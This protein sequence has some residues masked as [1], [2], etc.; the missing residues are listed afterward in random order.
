MCIISTVIKF[1][2]HLCIVYTFLSPPPSSISTCKNVVSIFQFENANPGK[3]L[4][5]HIFGGRC[6]VLSQR[7]FSKQQLSKGIYPSCNYQRVFIQ[8]ATSQVC[9][10]RS[11]LAFCSLFQHSARL[12]RPICS[13][14]PQLQP[15]GFNEF[16]LCLEFR[17]DLTTCFDWNIS[18]IFSV[19]DQDYNISRIFSVSDQDYNISRIFSLSHQD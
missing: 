6:Q 10:S 7:P 12:V 11:S 19:S 15:V 16:D 3:S 2:Q 18:T 9:S 8:A 14:W 13:A 17:D 1:L 4:N 5:S